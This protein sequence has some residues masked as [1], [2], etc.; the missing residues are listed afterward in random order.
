MFHYEGN[1]S[2]FE[3]LSSE[4]VKKL[5]FEANGESGKVTKTQDL[6]MPIK[7]NQNGEERSYVEEERASLK[8]FQKPKF[9]FSNP[10]SCSQEIIVSLN[11]KCSTVINF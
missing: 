3:A 7:Q 6:V 8:L 10:V 1:Y 11:G 4:K 2:S 9:S 5:N